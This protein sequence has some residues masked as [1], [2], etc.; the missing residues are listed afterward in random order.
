MTDEPAEPRP[1]PAEPRPEPAT[2]QPEPEAAPAWV[3]PDPIAPVPW[4]PPAAVET[5][6]R[7]AVG[8]EPPLEPTRSGSRPTLAATSR[9]RE[10]GLAADPAGRPARNGPSG[11]FGSG[12]RLW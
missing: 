10:A 9:L 2:R 12:D 6:E 1:E 8:G 3:G 5:A 4:A 11:P 7:G